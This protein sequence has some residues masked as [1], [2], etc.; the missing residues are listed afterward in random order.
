[1]LSVIG[2]AAFL[3]GYRSRQEALEAASRELAATPP[4]TAAPS[5]LIDLSAPNDDDFLRSARNLT[6][7]VVTRGRPAQAEIT[8][9]P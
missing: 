8:V 6:S 1:M 3:D 4:P 9:K 5:T 2:E 7:A